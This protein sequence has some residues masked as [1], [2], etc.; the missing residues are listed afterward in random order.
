MRNLIQQLEAGG[1]V[2]GVVHAAGTLTS[3]GLVDMDAEA[4]W[5]VCAV[6]TI[7]AFVLDQLLSDSNLDFFVMVS[8]FASTVGGSGQSHYAAVS[9]LDALARRLRNLPAAALCY[10]P[11]GLRRRA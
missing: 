8:S 6:K 1:G 10:G 9:Y 2:G 3:V 5:R 4:W 11:I 7:G